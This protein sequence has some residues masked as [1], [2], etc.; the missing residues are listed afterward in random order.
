LGAI[1]RLAQDHGHDLRVGAFDWVSGIGCAIQF[2]GDAL[3][4][5]LEILSNTSDVRKIAKAVSELTHAAALVE[6]AKAVHR[7]TRRL[8][9]WERPERR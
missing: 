4:Q 3:E 1:P 5:V 7:A 2:L 6:G 9:A 8:G